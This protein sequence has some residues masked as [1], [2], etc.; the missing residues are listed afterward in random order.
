LAKGPDRARLVVHPSDA[1][2]LSIV[3]GGDVRVR[4]RV[5]EVTVRATISDEVM[6][7]VVS[8]PHGFGHA[9]AKETLKIAGALAGTNAN[10]LTDEALVEPVLGTSILNGVPVSVS[11]LED[12]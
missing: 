11:K 2:R 9:S 8:L 4:S 10:A 1:A 6:P 12:A 5:G 7:G 3:D